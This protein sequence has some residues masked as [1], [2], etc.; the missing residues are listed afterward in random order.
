MVKQNLLLIYGLC[1]ALHRLCGNWCR[2][3]A[4]GHLSLEGLSR[5]PPPGATRP[6]RLNPYP[7]P[8][9]LQWMYPLYPPRGLAVTK[10]DLTARFGCSPCV[11]RTTLHTLYFGGRVSSHRITVTSGT[12]TKTAL[13][14]AVPGEPC[15][16]DTARMTTPLSP[17]L[18]SLHGLWPYIVKKSLA[19]NKRKRLFRCVLQHRRTDLGRKTARRLEA[20]AES[21][22]CD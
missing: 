7:A 15:S 12:K 21:R 14:P 20:E 1:R 4:G 2:T 11:S 16:G 6:H 9:S 18:T 10:G 8:S 19:P 22:G 3:R 17:K 5:R 13:L